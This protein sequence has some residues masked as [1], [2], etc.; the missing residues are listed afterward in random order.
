RS[1]EYMAVSGAQPRGTPSA[2]S[3]WAR[4]ATTALAGLIGLGLWTVFRPGLL[5]AD[6]I[7]QFQQ[8]LEG[9]VNDWHPPLMAGVLRALLALGGTLSQLTLAQCVA[10]TI[11]VTALAAATAR[12]AGVGRNAGRA[13]LVSPFAGLV[14]LLILLLPLSPLSYMLMT[15]WKDVWA[16]VA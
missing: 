14:V 6:S 8:A 11:G 2:P 1:E 10:G 4:V 5:S 3:S 15:F 13:S 9:P 7:S 12:L 16:L